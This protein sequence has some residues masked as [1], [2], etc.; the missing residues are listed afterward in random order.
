MAGD[1]MGKLFVDHLCEFGDET[2]AYSRGRFLEGTL[3]EEIDVGFCPDG[4]FPAV[5]PRGYGRSQ[6]RTPS[7]APSDRL[8]PCLL[9]QPSLHVAKASV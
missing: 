6:V 9:V 3:D 2:S 4:V 8:V 7:W 1:E 5:D